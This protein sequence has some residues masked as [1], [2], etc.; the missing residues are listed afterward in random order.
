M[1]KGNRFSALYVKDF[2][3]FWLG[4]IISLS[5]TWMHSVAQSWLVY[6]L[7]KSPLWLGIIAS[8]SSLPILL[9]TLIG[10]II[11]DRYPKRNILIITQFLSIIPALFLGILTDSG[12][13][14]VWHVGITATFLGTVN[15]FDIPTRQAFIGEV[16]GRDSLTNAI[17]LNSMAFNGAR[18]IG[19]MIAGLVIA[20]VGLPLCFYLNALSFAAVLFALTRISARGEKSADRQGIGTDIAD[21]L[22]YMIN[23][24]PV[25]WLMVIISLY[26]LF[27]IPYITLLPIIAGEVLDVGARGLSFLIAASGLGSFL[28]AFHIAYKGE[29][30]R[31]ELFIP[32]S[33]TVFSLAILGIA[34]SRNF[35]LSLAIAFFAG[36]GIVSFLAMSNSFI[37]H[38]APDA[39]RGRVMSLFTLVF[40][41]FAPLGNSII[42]LAAH[43]FGTV[44][45]LQVFSVICIMGTLI[46]GRSFRRSVRTLPAQGETT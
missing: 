22:R 39:L 25:F 16:A 11:A 21:G 29:I 17:A 9:F 45:S 28:A 14:R 8:L 34:Y 4:Q 3:L 32:F 37:Q 44:T 42:G 6:S 43:R 12:M 2:R 18:I 33:G 30:P 20:G 24:K 13:I 36:W 10:G 38:S 27:G 7:T 1:E 5:G 26:S 23:D 35:S 41:G 40:L 15:A 46:F 31:R 19:P